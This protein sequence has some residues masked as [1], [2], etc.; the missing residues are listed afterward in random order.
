MNGNEKELQ[1]DD[2]IERDASE[3]Y[4]CRREIMILL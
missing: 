1:W 3:L 4:S 2:V